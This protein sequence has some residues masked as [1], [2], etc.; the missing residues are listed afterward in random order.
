MKTPNQPH[1]LLITTLKQYGT[2]TPSEQFS[3]RLK[4]MVVSRYKISYTRRYHK[5]E[6]LGKWIIVVLLLSC[7]LV[8]IEMKPSTIVIEMLLPVFALA[9]GLLL[10]IRMLRKLADKIINQI[11]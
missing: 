2:A 10:L 5:E 4:N 8:F 11:R 3:S 1:D 6:W 7:V 9:L